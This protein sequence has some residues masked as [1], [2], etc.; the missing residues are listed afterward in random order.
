MKEKLGCKLFKGAGKLAKM[1]NAATVFRKDFLML[2]LMSFFPL[3][4]FFFYV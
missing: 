4:I 3:C 2:L 1:V